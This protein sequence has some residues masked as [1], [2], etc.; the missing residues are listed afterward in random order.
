MFDADVAIATARLTLRPFGPQD[1]VRVRSVVE[2]GARFLPPGAPAQAA[3][4]AAWLDR[5]VHE[6]RRSGQGIH[7]AMT[8]VDGVIVGAISLFKTSWEAGT[9]E[10]GYGVHPLYR[11]R[12]LATEALRGL[13]EWVFD[14]TRLRRIDLTANLDNLPSLRVAQKAGFTWEGV[15]RGAVMEDDGPHDLVVFGLLRG[16]GRGPAVAL[17]RAELRTARL[18]LRAPEPADAA[19]LAATGADPLTQARTGVPR[20]YG[21]EH[22]LAFI[23]GA[24]RVRLRG[25]GIAFSAVESATGRFAV[26]VDLRDLDWTNRTAEI[27]YMTAPWARGRGYAGEAVLGVARWLFERQGF[28]RLQLRAAVDNPQS[29]RVAEKAGFT[30]EGVARAALAGEDLVVFSLIPSDLAFPGRPEGTPS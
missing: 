27:G 25:A 16:D 3:G 4:V 23:D 9:T 15:L 14:K 12:G 22:A 26:N 29:Q 20:G 6:L 7:L 2:S 30:R 10:V 5:G 19:D 8:D 11:G 28:S 18:L 17:P 1:A 24:E 13:V 21:V